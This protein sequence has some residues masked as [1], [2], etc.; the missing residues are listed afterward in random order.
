V[1][2]AVVLLALAAYRAGRP[3][4]ALTIVALVLIQIALG[5]ETLLSGVGL[6]IAVAHQATAA[7]LLAAM[8]WAAHGIGAPQHNRRN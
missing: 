1:A 2:I 3:G 6:P 4:R 5:I 8:I 7:L